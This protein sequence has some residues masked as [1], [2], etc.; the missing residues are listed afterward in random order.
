MRENRNSLLR[1]S[2][3]FASTFRKTFVTVIGRISFGR[4]GFGIPTILS[5]NQEGGNHPRSIIT[6]IHIINFVTEIGRSSTT[7]FNN[8]ADHPSAP[9][10]E[11]ESIDV[12]TSN[13][14][15]SLSKHRI[16]DSRSVSGGEER[17]GEEERGPRTRFACEINP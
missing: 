7:F 8:A 5:T 17:E 6:F 14:S 16:C 11:L 1:E 4:D 10:A 3:D 9:G 12:I 2:S 13:K 15:E